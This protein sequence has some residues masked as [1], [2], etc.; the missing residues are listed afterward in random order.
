MADVCSIANDLSCKSK[1][2]ETLIVMANSLCDVNMFSFALI[3]ASTGSTTISRTVFVT[4][5]GD[6]FAGNRGFAFNGDWFDLFALARD[7]V[8]K[9]ASTGD[10]LKLF[11]SKGD[12]V[13]ICVSAGDFVTSVGD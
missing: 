1:Q 6:S 8:E 2:N 7:F 4:V 11:A 12:C 9:F 13:E 3:C 10:C 5:T